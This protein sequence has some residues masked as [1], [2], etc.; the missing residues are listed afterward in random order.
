MISFLFITKRIYNT[1]WSTVNLLSTTFHLKFAKM[2]NY[3]RTA[4]SDL[5]FM[6]GM[7]LTIRVYIRKPFVHLRSISHNLHVNDLRRAVLCTYN[8]R[9]LVDKFTFHRTKETVTAKC[10]LELTSFEL[11]HSIDNTYCQLSLA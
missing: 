7:T 3:L 9:F 1:Y 2:S 6:K 10:Y 11:C 5:M 8:N 4:L